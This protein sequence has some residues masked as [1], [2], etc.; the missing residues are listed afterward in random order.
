MPASANRPPGYRHWLARGPDIVR[1][2]ATTPPEMTAEALLVLV[3]GLMMAFP[4]GTRLILLEHSV[5][6]SADA[7]VM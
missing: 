7:M 3:G 2:A 5:C 1:G 4:D 6:V